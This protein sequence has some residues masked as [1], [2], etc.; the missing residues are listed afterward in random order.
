MVNRSY[1]AA[2]R[3]A[4]GPKTLNPNSSK[5]LTL[6]AEAKGVSLPSMA[7]ICYEV[8]KFLCEPLSAF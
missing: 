1:H 7:T 3:C 8:S 4:Q 6:D 2:L 5:T